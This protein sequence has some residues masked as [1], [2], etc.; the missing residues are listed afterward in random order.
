M[1]RRRLLLLLFSF[2]VAHA[3]A[4]IETPPPM[5]AASMRATYDQVIGHLDPGGGILMY[6]NTTDLI[7]G[8]LAQGEALLDF[9]PDQDVEALAVKARIQAGIDFLMDNGIN[10]VTAVG[11]ST[12]PATDG[13][14]TVRLFVGQKPDARSRGLWR[15]LGGPPRPMKSHAYL[16]ADA[17]LVR[18]ANVVPAA[19]WDLVLDGIGRIAGPDMAAMIQAQLGTLKAQAGIDVAAILESLGDELMVSLLLDPEAMLT[20][21][22][23]EG[24]LEVPRPSL[25]MGLATRDDTLFNL[26]TNQLA[27]LDLPLEQ[28]TIDGRNVLTLEQPLPLP[29]PVQPAVTQVENLLLIASSPDILAKAFAATRGENALVKDP[30]FQRLLSP[31]PTDLN[32]LVYL[33]PRLYETVT[34]LQVAA[35][36]AQEAEVA[37]LLQNIFHSAGDKALGLV[38][39]NTPDGIAISGRSASSGRELAGAMAVA[40][41]AVLGAVALPAVAKAREQAQRTACASNLHQVDVAKQMWRQDH[42]NQEAPPSQDDLAPFFGNE[43]VTCPQ[44]GAYTLGGLEDQPACSLHGTFE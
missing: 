39:I 30:A 2:H 34:R 7:Q 13:L 22:G 32:G 44:G 29:I 6:L 35:A 38:R 28:R 17:V 10:D 36:S 9:I 26:M 20:I 33:S 23:P 4:E 40:P 42:P 16:P 5:D 24:D 37:A 27:T 25:L 21:P 18:S 31:L 19:A 11:F 1:N 15:L 43:W 3:H 8:L 14:Q 12:A 41:A